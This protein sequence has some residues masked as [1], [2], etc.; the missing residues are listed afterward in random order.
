MA[1]VLTIDDSRFVRLIIK[2]II[3]ESL[4]GWSVVEAAS[5]KEARDIIDVH[6]NID[7]AI[8]DNNMPGGS[9]LELIPQLKEKIVS[10]NIAML[11]ADIQPGMK[12]RV[13]ALGVSLLCKPVTEELI[14]GFLKRKPA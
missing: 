2:N 12:V 5:N 10:E 14:L 11:T 4:P 1:K 6:D 9:G 8:V 3:T 13:E 7:Y